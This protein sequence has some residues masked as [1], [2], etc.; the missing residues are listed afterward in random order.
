[1][2]RKTLLL[3]IVLLFPTLVAAQAPQEKN[4]TE[5]TDKLR[6][7]AVAFLRET[8]SDVNAMRSIENRISFTSELA[9]LMWFYDEREARAMYVTVITDFRDLI[10]KYDSQMNALP[11]ATEDDAPGPMNFSFMVFDPTDRQ[12][13]S[14]KFT[15]A[16]GVRQQIATSMAEHDPDLAFGFYYESSSLIVNPE[17]RAQILPGETHFESQLLRQLAEKNPEKAAKFGKRSLEKGVNSYHIELLKKIYEKDADRGIEFADA[18]V[19]RLKSETSDNLSIISA[20]I[21]FGGET[22]E[23]AG[24]P[25]SKAPVFTAAELRELVE[26]VAQNILKRNAEDIAPAAAHL[27]MIEKY[28]PGRAAQIRAKFKTGPWKGYSNINANVSAFGVGDP[29]EEELRA[30]GISNS[31]SNSEAVRRRE[32]AEKAEQELMDDVQNLAEKPLPKEE[33]DK[34]IAQARKIISQTRGR[35]KK[36]PALS[37]LAAQ[38]AKLGDKELAAEI[39]RDAE[40]LVNPTPKN[41]QD[42]ILSWMLATGYAVAEPDKAFP[43]LEETIGRANETLAAVVK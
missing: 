39:M 36:I 6:K 30:Y 25:D 28:L 26:V 9:G 16:M 20:L 5:K 27:A 22:L 40:R 35:D 8:L 3:I 42:F 34:I 12:R 1:M 38:V 4:A 29:S 10:A 37:F 33:R 21:E 7:D 24:R 43:L 23:G 31:N 13:I 18:I 11:P 32:A 2:Y 15:V 41:Y 19:A 17:L 14:R